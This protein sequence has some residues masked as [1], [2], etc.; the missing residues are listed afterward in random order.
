[1]NKLQRLKKKV[2]I[3]GSI[4]GVLVVACLGL[5][6]FISSYSEE[7][8]M[9]LMMLR[10]QRS[11]IESNNA[12]AIE[13]NRVA[14]E[15]M[16]VYEKINPQDNPL[17]GTLDRKK[18]TITLDQLNQ[19]YK[20]KNLSLNISPAAIRDST[21]LQL[22]SGTVS[23]STVTISFE[24]M[25][26]EFALAFMRDIIASFPGFMH[27]TSVGLTKNGSIDSKIFYD[28]ASGE[29]P[30]MVKGDF[31]FEWLGM[32]IKNKNENAVQAPVN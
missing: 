18:A 7:G 3:T 24:S 9:R 20:L 21:P 23:S 11:T 14:Q 25:T 16:E 2:I 10:S 22:K 27:I 30:S 31:S 28:T 5:T 17:F 26:D 15:T 8:E 13:R 19:Q 6:Y 29:M 12:A 4:F 32:D 1:M